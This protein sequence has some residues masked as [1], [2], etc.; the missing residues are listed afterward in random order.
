MN[1][2]LLEPRIAPAAL[3]SFTDLDGDLVTISSSKGT[4]AQLTTAAGDLTD[5]Q[6]QNLDLTGTTDFAGANIS[7]VAKQAP[8]G[9]GDGRV[10]VGGISSPVD[11]GTVLVDGDLGRIFAGDGDTKVAG[12]RSLTV[13]SL[14]RFGTSTGAPDLET[15]IKDGLGTLTVQTDV[16]DAKITVFG[17]VSTLK[18][19]GS[20]DGRGFG[21]GGF[22]QITVG[23]IGSATVGGDMIGGAATGSGSILAFGNTTI[24]KVTVGG[25]L[26]GGPGMDSAKI[27]CGT[28]T[29]ATIGGDVIGGGATGAG[30][31]EFTKGGTITIA[32]SLIGGSATG[33]GAVS[34]G[35][36]SSA[37]TSV[38]IGHNVVGGSAGNTGAV[39]ALGE[40]KSITI[41][42]DVVGGSVADSGLLKSSN[43]K[44]GTLTIA[45]SLVGNGPSSGIAQSSSDMGKV[46]I[47]HDLVGNAIRSGRIISGGAIKTVSVGGS[48]LGG[49]GDFSGRI[50][51][52]GDITS[53]TI[54]HDLKAG[55]GALSGSVA[56]SHAIGTMLVK[57]S[58]LG[59]GTVK[60]HI[61]ANASIARLTVNGRVE[62][63]RVLAGYNNDATQDTTIGGDA[64]IGTVTVAHDWIASDLVAGANDNLDGSFG[65]NDQ[66]IGICDPAI[67]SKIASIV[68]KGQA[69][70]TVGGTDHFGFVAQDLGMLKIGDATFAFTAAA[71]FQNKAIGVTGDLNALEV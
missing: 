8:G 11:L 3:V 27:A 37:I 28:L 68:I 15:S 44:I 35:Q 40:I 4:V 71:Q 52:T 38:K 43:S 58:V 41:G 42:G 56:S 22:F 21:G 69:L 31:L 2:E 63:A 18:I 64:Q 47:G 57:G 16:K 26:L 39:V 62:L 12:V 17:T 51:S 70:G 53:L 36:T 66:S 61:L 50:L 45:G 60:A 49:A 59:N 33:A 1:I 13:L 9:I 23:N 19:G 32:G 48:V 29:S 30:A 14:G 5:H 6:L 7:I 24:G 25:S 34:S 55:A 54:G 46:T 65:S 10:N 67:R 20:L